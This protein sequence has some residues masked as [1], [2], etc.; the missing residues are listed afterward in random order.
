MANRIKI[1]FQVNSVSGMMSIQHTRRIGS[2]P[3]KT[4]SMATD[5]ELRGMSS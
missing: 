4:W 1:S 3:D 2:Q 5:S